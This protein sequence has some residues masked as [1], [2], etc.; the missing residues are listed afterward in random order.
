VSASE[1]TRRHGGGESLASGKCPHKLTR[2]PKREPLSGTSLSE[3]GYLG[4]GITIRGKYRKEEF[5]PRGGG[6][7]FMWGVINALSRKK[8]IPT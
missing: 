3:R 5:L 4:V 8:R 1:G 6:D 7:L 2:P